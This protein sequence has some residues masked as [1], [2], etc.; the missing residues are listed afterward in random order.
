MKI[1]DDDDGIPTDFTGQV[2]RALVNFSGPN[3][4]DAAP[5]RGLMDD[6]HG[7]FQALASAT[8]CGPE[9]KSVI[10]PI[11]RVRRRIRMDKYSVHNAIHLMHPFIT[12]RRIIVER[13]VCNKWIDLL[14]HPSDVA[15]TDAA[16]IYTTLIHMA[17]YSGVALRVLF[18]GWQR[19]RTPRELMAWVRSAGTTITGSN[20][21]WSS[22]ATA[23]AGRVA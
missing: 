19:I 12:E 13:S 22:S 8:D 3:H 9:I 7:V 4:K 23:A 21:W 6:I 2:Q 10:Y 18:T 5:V 14:Q 15:A 17:V 20:A 16:F 11:L 1:D